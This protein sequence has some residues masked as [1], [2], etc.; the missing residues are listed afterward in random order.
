MKNILELVIN[1]GFDTNTNE[2]KLLELDLI[3][4]DGA[5]E[6][7]VEKIEDLETDIENTK[8]GFIL[9][10]E[11][12][13]MGFF[14][15]ELVSFRNLERCELEPCEEYEHLDNDEL[16]ERITDLYDSIVGLKS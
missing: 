14:L 1:M 3:E 15:T 12:V 9:H 8:D 16:V 5:C 4:L 10:A 11:N 2:F 13:A 6:E 7:L